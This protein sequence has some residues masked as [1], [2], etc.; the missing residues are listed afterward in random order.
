MVDLEDPQPAG[1][2]SPVGQRIEPGAK[3]HKLCRTGIDGNGKRVFG[4]ARS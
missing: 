1:Q 2:M 3:H 4:D